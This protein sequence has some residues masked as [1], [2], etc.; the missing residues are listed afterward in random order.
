MSSFL[1][2]VAGTDKLNQRDLI[3]DPILLFAIWGLLKI[4]SD[5]MGTAILE[6]D[7]WAF[8]KLMRLTH[9]WRTS[10]H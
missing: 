8:S 3:T 4:I 1:Q 10:K 7:M 9:R 5:A 6:Y 2:L